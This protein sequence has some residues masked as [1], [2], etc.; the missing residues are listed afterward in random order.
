MLLI[1]TPIDFVGIMI[2]TIISIITIV[3]HDYCMNMYIYI[4]THT[5]TH[6]NTHAS[7]HITTNMIKQLRYIKLNAV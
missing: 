1:I 6:I 7:M 4:Y 5:Y 2:V 3:Y